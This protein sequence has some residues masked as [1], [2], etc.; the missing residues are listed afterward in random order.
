[1]TSTASAPAETTLREVI[2]WHATT[3]AGE[4]F[5]LGAPGADHVRF[6]DLQEAVSVWAERCAGWSPGER[7]GLMVSDPLAFV[8]SF[9]GLLAAGFWV[10]PL[11][12]TNSAPTPGARARLLST[13]RLQRVLADRPA[14]AGVTL[15]WHELSG[16]WSR[17][18]RVTGSGGVILASSG[19]T[20]VP[21]VMALDEA[22]LLAAARQI[23]QH[24]RLGPRDRGL[25]PLPLWHVNAEVVAVLASLSAGASLVLEERFRRTGFWARAAEREV[26]WIN[27]VPAIIARL[28][29]LGD[30]DEVPASLRFV[31]SA[32]APL[33]ASL[34]ARFEARTG[35]RVIESYGMTEAAS[36]ICAT[37]LDAERPAGSVGPGVG[38]E[39]RVNT[40]G[41]GESGE[42]G[43]VEIRGRSVIDHYESPGYEARFGEGGWLVTGDLGYLDA[44]GNL[45]LVG[46]SDDV[47]NR[48]GE[49]IYPREI[50]EI[51]LE[52]PGVLGAA[53][54]GVA[55]DVFGQVPV[56]Y[57]ELGDVD[58][59]GVLTE[60][61][62]SLIAELARVRRPAEI[63]VVGQLPRHAT[64]KLRT[65][66]LD[67]VRVLH[68]ER[69][70]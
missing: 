28:V 46:R 4:T 59:G 45:Y 33:S 3:R 27:A 23:A 30:D 51:A 34:L 47:I 18:E 63:R 1:M 52:L 32:S 66:E 64:G 29:E 26:T 31:R 38:V 70:R 2:A 43:S 39:V 69:L 6:A 21:K 62:A 15:P 61:R 16:P 50:E 35:V 49:K 53:V 12:P 20:G 60:L 22:R 5:L 13:L 54:V 40:G 67:A 44:R 57:V 10:A 48:G 7:V 58:R 68:V 56:L 19:T 8:Q 41:R 65:R 55:D 36:Q 24:H 11:D 42:V 37:S 17:G 14:P 9:L 25:N